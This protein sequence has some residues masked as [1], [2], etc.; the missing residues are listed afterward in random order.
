SLIGAAQRNR[1]PILCVL[2]QYLD[3]A[4]CGI[5]GH[6]VALGSGQPTTHFR[7]TFPHTQGIPATSQAQGLSS[8]K[9]PLYL[10][11]NWDWEQVGR[12]SP[13]SRD[14]H[15]HDP[16]QPLKCTEKIFRAGGHLL[17]LKA[18]LAT[19]GPHKINERSL[20]GGVGHSLPGPRGPS[21]WP[22]P[23]ENGGHASQQVPDIPETVTPSFSCMLSSPPK[24]LLEQTQT[25]SSC[26]PGLGHEDW[27]CPVWGLLAGG[28]RAA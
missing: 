23:G 10:D 17:T 8:V 21:Q 12:D 2:G 19:Y 15:Q 1:E 22:V 26:F 28:H 6:E 13:R 11:L 18:L 25:A 27:P 14:L 9:A 16:H 7:Q 24:P 3:P 5:R 20:P 4:Q